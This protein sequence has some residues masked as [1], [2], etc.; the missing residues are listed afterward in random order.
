MNCFVTSLRSFTERRIINLKVS[1]LSMQRINNMGSLLQAYGLKRLLEG[2]DKSN[3]TF[4]DI[5]RINEDYNLLNERPQDFSTEHEKG[6]VL[7]K[8]R[9]IDKYTFNRLKIRKM[10]MNQNTYF[11]DFRKQYLDIET[12]YKNCDLCVIGSDEVFNCLNAGNWGFS[13]QLFGNIP[14]AKKIITYAASCGATNY[15]SLPLKVAD[16]IKASFKNIEAFSVRD[17]NTH[18]FVS[19]LTDKYIV[20]SLDPVLIYNFDCEVEGIEMPVVPEKYCIVYSYYNRFH[21]KEEIKRVTS[22]CKRNGLTPVAIGAPQFWIKE[23]II[24]SP[25]QCLKIFQNAEFVI[26]DTFHGTILATKYSK[27]FAVM[28]RKSNRNKLE[29]LIKRLKIDK[30]LIKDINSLD[31]AYKVV[32]NTDSIN[33]IIREEQKKTMYYLEGN[34]NKKNE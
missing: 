6:G 9:K 21:S 27:R 30:H 20:Q 23:Y 19:K 29:D 5:K 14:E 7:G 11:E 22:F 24:C 17:N 12:T 16:R 26:T 10:A 25:F 4:K 13:S 3:V 2:V 1:I 15:D 34:I 33:R 8:I 18:D 28:T 31:D 32:K